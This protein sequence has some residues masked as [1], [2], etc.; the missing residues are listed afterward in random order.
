MSAYGTKQTFRGALAM[1][2]LSGVERTCTVVRL[3]PPR[4]LMTRSGHRPD[5]NVAAQQSPAVV[6]CATL[7]SEARE[8]KLVRRREFIALLGGA[9]AWPLAAHAQQ[10]R[11]RRIGLLMHTAAD[12]PESTARLAAFM[13]VLQELGWAVGRNMRIDYRWSVG[14]AARVRKDATELVA[15]GPEVIL[16]G[17]GPS[18]ATSQ[19]HGADRHGTG[20]GPGRQWLRRQSRATRRQYHWVH[21]V[22]IRLG[23]EVGGASQGEIGRAHV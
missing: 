10:E 21:S 20:P 12:D 22:R 6:R 16:A 2:P 7:R 8:H 1:C 17:V 4:A 23:W 19:S 14:D 18:T 13:Q 5:R 11:M 15:L 9:A 3:Q